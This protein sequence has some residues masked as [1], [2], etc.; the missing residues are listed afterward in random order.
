MNIAETNFTRFI[1]GFSGF[2]TFNVRLRF[3][4]LH[5]IVTSHNL[6]CSELLLRQNRFHLT[7]SSC[8]HGH[9]KTFYIAI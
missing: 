1:S 4:Q 5:E 9:I 3:T 8:L 7:L 6:L 2:L